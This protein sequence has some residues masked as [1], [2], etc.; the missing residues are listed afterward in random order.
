VE[1][2]F[3]RCLVACQLYPDF[4]ARRAAHYEGRGD[5]EAAR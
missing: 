1:Q 2:V 4:W 3:D 5:V